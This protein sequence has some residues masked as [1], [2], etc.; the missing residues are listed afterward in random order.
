MASVDTSLVASKRLAFSNIM[1]YQEGNKVLGDHETLFPTDPRKEGR[2]L[3]A[4]L[5]QMQKHSAN[6]E[7]VV[8]YKTD[9]LTVL[10]QW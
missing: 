9:F 4:A 10:Q 7:M 1:I 8:R 3:R 5:L 6:V 2:A